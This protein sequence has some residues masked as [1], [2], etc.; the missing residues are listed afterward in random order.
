MKI[1]NLEDLKQAKEAGLSKLYP[2]AKPKI[3]VGMATCGLTVG[4]QNVFDLFRKRARASKWDGIVEKTGCIGLCYEEPL[5]DLVLPG[6][7]R[8]TYR[9]VNPD[10]AEKIW[11][12]LT[13]GKIPETNLFTWLDTDEMLLDGG[14]RRLHEGAPEEY[15]RGVPKYTE[16]EFVKFQKHVAMRNCGFLD[17][18]SLEHYIARGGYFALH[19]AL[20]SMQPEEVIGQIIESGLRGRGGGG[21]PTGIKW[22][23]CRKAPGEPKYVLCNADEGNPGTYTDRGLI[24]GDPHSILEGMLIGAYAIG[25]SEGY[26]YVRAEYPLA[27]KTL[28]GAISGGSGRRVAGQRYPGHGI[29]FRYQNQPGGRSV[30]MRRVHGLDGVHRRKTRGSPRQVCPYCREG[31]LG[32]TLQSEQRGNLGQRA[33]HHRQRVGLV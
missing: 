31:S 2:A 33:G 26:I 30:C 25:A 32:K 12:D 16:L 28:K 13:H 10:T 5:V 7:P 11:G 8:L 17:P 22:Q 18:D 23:S 24:E 27:V 14:V 29:R 1:R 3:L 9:Q 19:K 21:F 4:A 20:S 6:K 15:L